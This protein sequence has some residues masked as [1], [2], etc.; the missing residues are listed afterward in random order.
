M[1]DPLVHR[2]LA[3]SAPDDFGIRAESDDRLARLFAV[4]VTLLPRFVERYRHLLER[5]RTEGPSADVRAQAL[6]AAGGL[7]AVLHRLRPYEPLLGA[8]DRRVLP[9]IPVLAALEELFASFVLLTELEPDAE[10][11][12]KLTREQLDELVGLP[13]LERMLD[14]HSAGYWLRRLTKHRARG[15]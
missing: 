5:S 8:L 9:T 15:G 1:T 2:L 11:D 7:A 14:P 13:Q 10:T 6:D 12:V 3:G 4:A